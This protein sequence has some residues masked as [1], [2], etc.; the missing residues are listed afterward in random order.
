MLHLRR[1]IAALH[2]LLVAFGL[3]Y[4]AVP[5]WL[6]PPPV[7]RPAAAEHVR[8]V[9]TS[10]SVED[11]LARLFPEDAW[12]RD[13]K[14]KVVETSQCLLLVRDYLPTPDGR[15]EL[16]P[17]TVVFYA[18]DSPD[19]AA[20]AATD[21]RRTPARSS[22]K[23]Q[24]GAVLQF[25]KPLEIG[26]G[27]FGQIIG[28][29]LA[30]EI[31]ISSPPSSPTSDDALRLVM[32]EVQIKPEHILRTLRIRVSLRPAHR[33]GPRSDDRPV[34]ATREARAGRT[35]PSFKGSAR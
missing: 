29:R 19:S 5:P 27:E 22:C 12:E 8:P 16:K 9:Q 34:C 30:G 7:I 35:S 6:E 18:N 11:D 33:P 10:S 32:R 26:R 2:V 1:Y 4:V 21:A 31:T 3:Y 23:P 13:P 24:A 25:D 28:G 20:G 17:C 14:T 15:L